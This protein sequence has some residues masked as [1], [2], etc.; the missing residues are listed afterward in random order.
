MRKPILAI[1]LMILSQ[2]PS[3]AATKPTDQVGIIN[4]ESDPNDE[5][6]EKSNKRYFKQWKQLNLDAKTKQALM[7]KNKSLD[8]EIEKFRIGF[9]Y[10]FNDKIIRVA[11]YGD[12]G[13][14]VMMDWPA[15]S[16]CKLTFDS[17]GGFAGVR[18]QACE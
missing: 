15:G 18:G 11:F 3:L 5:A 6:V 2:A 10:I 4:I 8:A 16:E 13:S 17:Q 12:Y 14:A 1:A 9:L 7:A